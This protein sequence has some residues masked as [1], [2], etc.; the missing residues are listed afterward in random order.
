MPSQ[1]KIKIV[2]A[3]YVIYSIKQTFKHVVD[4]NARFASYVIYSIK[5][6]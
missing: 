1:V 4:I 6:T 3:S 2:F 5:Q